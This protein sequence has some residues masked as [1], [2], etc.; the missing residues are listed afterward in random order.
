MTNSFITLTV[1]DI[2]SNIIEFGE[3]QLTAIQNYT[4]QINYPSYFLVSF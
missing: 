1:T 3:N 4:K 2:A